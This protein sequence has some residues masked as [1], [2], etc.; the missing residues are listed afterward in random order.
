MSAL[1]P[2][3]PSAAV[4]EARDELAVVIR[5][6]AEAMDRIDL[7]HVRKAHALLVRLASAQRETA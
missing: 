5:Y 4:R 1:Q 2:I 6:G 7:E 3:S